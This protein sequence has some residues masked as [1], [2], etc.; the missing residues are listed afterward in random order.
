METIKQSDNQKYFCEIVKS[1]KQKELNDK[2]ETQ[3]EIKTVDN[4]SAYTR[5][6]K[7]NTNK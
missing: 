4:D 2:T 1:F 3:I 6:N 5:E 7:L